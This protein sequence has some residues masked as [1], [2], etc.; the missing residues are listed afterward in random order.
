MYVWSESSA[1][2][3]YE[4]LSALHFFNS[5]KWLYPCRKLYISLPVAQGI[6]SVLLET[7]LLYIIDGSLYSI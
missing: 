4:V 7:S 3:S 5:V 1:E 6:V 2:W